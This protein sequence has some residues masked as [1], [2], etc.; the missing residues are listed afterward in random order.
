[1]ATDWYTGTGGN[2]TTGDGTSHAT[3]WLTIQKALDNMTTAQPN[4]LNCTGSETLSASLDFTT[5]GGPSTDNYLRFQGYTTTAED[6]GIFALNGGTNEIIAGDNRSA[7]KFRH[8][9]F[10]NWGTGTAFSMDNNCGWFECEFDGEGARSAVLDGDLHTQVICCKIHGI[11][12]SAVHAITGVTSSVF[13]YNYI[14]MDSM[15][16]FWGVLNLSIGGIAEGNVFSIKSPNATSAIIYVSGDGAEVSNNTIFN[17]ST[18]AGYG[19]F[20]DSTAVEDGI[21]LNNII[22]GMAQGVKVDA[23][24]G[25]SLYGFNKFFSNTTDEQLD[26]FVVCNLGS[27]TDLGANPLTTTGSADHNDDDFTVDTTVKAGAYPTELYDPDATQAD[28][29]QQFID[30]GA[31]QREEP[32][33]GGGG[34]GGGA[35]NVII[36]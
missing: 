15:A 10:T 2:D 33:G 30:S 28:R 36:S 4:N 19:I 20:L 25:L 17:Q 5:Y 1:M 29:N 35:K 27:N 26:G 32:A 22:G 9:K 12:G 21:V 11:I 34:G 16:A 23:G 7:I 6:G 13:K 14:Q 3:R 31:L 24:A 8:F 18:A